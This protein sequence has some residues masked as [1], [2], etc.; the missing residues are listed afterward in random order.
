MGRQRA[1]IYLFLFLLVVGICAER[2]KNAK[3]RRASEQARRAQEWREQ[4]IA[5]GILRADA[6]RAEAELKIAREASEAARLRS[7][8]AE[9][10]R[11]LADE[12]LRAARARQPEVIENVDGN[13]FE[14]LMNR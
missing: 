11:R 12:K 14:R 1:M 6:A 13:D 8:D 10:A 5:N 3:R 9:M 7:Q 4:T 2:A